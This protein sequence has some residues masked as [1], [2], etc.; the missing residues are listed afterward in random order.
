MILLRNYYKAENKRGTP[1]TKIK[2]E[3]LEIL[4]VDI[5][6]ENHLTSPSGPLGGKYSTLA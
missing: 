3:D 6:A 5:T 2:T 1:T 4:I